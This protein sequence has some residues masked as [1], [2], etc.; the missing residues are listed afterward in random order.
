MFWS[1]C[2]CANFRED[3]MCGRFPKYHFSLKIKC[4]MQ[5]EKYRVSREKIYQN[6]DKQSEF[7]SFPTI[8]SVKTRVDNRLIIF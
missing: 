2:S 5:Q 4:N 8:Y 6:M 1:L 7:I 3:R